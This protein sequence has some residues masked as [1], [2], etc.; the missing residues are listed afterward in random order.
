[1]ADKSIQAG[2]D[3]IEKIFDTIA[4]SPCYSPLNA[5][6]ASQSC[7]EDVRR[8]L[9]ELLKTLETHFAEE[10]LEMSRYAAPKLCEPH[11]KLHRE[12]LQDLQTLVSAHQ[13]SLHYNRCVEG[14]KEFS[15][16]YQHHLNTADVELMK[17]LPR[18]GTVLKKA[19]NLFS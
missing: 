10:L 13:R 4:K 15:A 17:F 2:H 3:A 14:I 9:D 6:C 5:T 8:T 16:K 19:R 1:M 18:M 11:D 7:K 12:L